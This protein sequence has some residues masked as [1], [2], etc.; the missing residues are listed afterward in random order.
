MVTCRGSNVRSMDNQP[1]TVKQ[2]LKDRILWRIYVLWFLR[3]IAPLIV[4]QIAVFI[5]VFRIFAKNVFI[6]KVFRNAAYAADFGYWS[7]LKYSFAAFLNAHLITQ[8][9]ILL[10]LGVAALLLRDLMRV[11]VAYK[12]MWKRI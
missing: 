3:R 6:S 11:L 4:L 9:S 2:L 1:A 7:L 5:L 10:I 12:A 8:V